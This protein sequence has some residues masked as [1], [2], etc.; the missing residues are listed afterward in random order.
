MSDAQQAAAEVNHL[1]PRKTRIGNGAKCVARIR[2]H[3]SLHLGMDLR[4]D[5]T[6]AVFRS[7]RGDVRI[8][9]VPDAATGALVL[10]A[11]Y[12][13]VLNSSAFE[14]FHDDRYL[15]EWDAAHAAFD[16]M[17]K[18]FSPWLS[19]QAGAGVETFE[20]QH[21]LDEAIQKRERRKRH[22]MQGL[23]KPVW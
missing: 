1:D 6:G 17:M 16:E 7:I 15:W 11:L 23:L 12:Y 14:E 5:G 10:A 9:E 13:E 21:D 19:L 4:P 2:F 3:E 8:I 22:V 18:E 20:E